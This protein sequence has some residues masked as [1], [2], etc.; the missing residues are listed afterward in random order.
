MSESSRTASGA[1]GGGGGNDPYDENDEGH[2]GTDQGDDSAHY[3]ASVVLLGRLHVSSGGTGRSLQSI[4][5]GL[6]R[7]LLT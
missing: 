3:G 5:T 1:G 7:T 6:V 2:D 4:E